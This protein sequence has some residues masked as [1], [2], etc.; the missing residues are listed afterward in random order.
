[1]TV[2]KYYGVAGGPGPGLYTSWAR[3]QAA[4]HDHTGAKWQGF[5]SPRGAE[6]WLIEQGVDASTIKIF[7]SH[8]AQYSGFEPESN[9]SFDEEFQRLAQSQDWIPNSQQYHE[10]RTLA[11][12]SKLQNEY[13]EPALKY[14]QSSQLTPEQCKKQE[15]ERKIRGYQSLLREINQA[16]RHTVEKCVDVLQSTLVNI[17][18]LLDARR[19]GTKVGVFES[20]RD[21]K[22][23]TMKPG[24]R[25]RLGTAKKNVFLV[26]P[27]TKPEDS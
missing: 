21:F 3:A 11:I 25:I 2:S 23:H 14:E 13:W 18:D 17:V 9:T 8:F 20:F 1:M 6:A 4:F 5:D 16:P 19:T 12:S 15:D 7:S 24:K 10:Q 27:P 22:A 26:D